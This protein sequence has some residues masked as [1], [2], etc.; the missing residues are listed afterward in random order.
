MSLRHE[1]NLVAYHWR[2]ALTIQVGEVIRQLEGDSGLLGCFRNQ[3]SCPLTPA[4]S[5][6]GALGKAEHAFFEVLNEYT[7][8]DLMK[9]G[10]FA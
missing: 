4:C 10:S 1:V 8:S 3:E 9:N 5:F 2:W 7:V 6:K